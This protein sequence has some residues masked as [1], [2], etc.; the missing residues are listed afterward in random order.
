VRA[1]EAE[2]CFIA[3][4]R[5]KGFRFLFYI[6][7][8]GSRPTT[9]KRESLSELVELSMLPIPSMLWLLPALPAPSILSMDAL[10]LL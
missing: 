6:R 2:D 5:R 4:P 8:G 9:T 7:D 3:T 10:L 1:V